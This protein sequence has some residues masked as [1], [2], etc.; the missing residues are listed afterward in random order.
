MAILHVLLFASNAAP[1]IV[2]GQ[3]LAAHLGV[4][5]PRVEFNKPATAYIP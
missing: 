5:S 1:S 3:N 2:Q 4:L